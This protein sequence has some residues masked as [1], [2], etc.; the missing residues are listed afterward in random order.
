M[1]RGLETWSAR[2]TSLDFFK[3]PWCCVRGRPIM[4]EDFGNLMCVLVSRGGFLKPT[5]LQEKKSRLSPRRKKWRGGSGL[6]QRTRIFPSCSSAC[7]RGGKRKYSYSGSFAILNQW[8]GG[9][10][11]PVPGAPDHLRTFQWNT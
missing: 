7:K 11:S 1:V 6:P 10:D 2:S 9:L 4:G 8:K 5:R 3:R